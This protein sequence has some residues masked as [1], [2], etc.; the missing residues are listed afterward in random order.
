MALRNYKHL[1]D[2]MM[3][4]SDGEDL[5]D[6]ETDDRDDDENDEIDSEDEIGDENGE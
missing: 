3:Y 5:D 4:L 1:L 6:E 2:E